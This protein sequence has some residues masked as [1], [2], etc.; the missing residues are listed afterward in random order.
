MII[1]SPMAAFTDAERQ[2]RADGT[3]PNMTPALIERVLM[4]KRLVDRHR[5]N[6]CRGIRGYSCRNGTLE[7]VPACLRHLSADELQAVELLLRWA[8]PL[9]DRW[10]SQLA[11]VCWFWPV[12]EAGRFMDAVTFMFDWQQSR[13]AI[14]GRPGRR[15]GTRSDSLVLDHDHKSGIARGFLCHPC[16]KREGLDRPGDGRYANYRRRPPA[17]LLGFS[18]PYDQRRP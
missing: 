1:P 18:V 8:Q 2:L 10:L 12:P 16:N 5:T 3:A 9:V 4:A 17:A 14:C 6:W 13:C 11:P 15:G 7:G